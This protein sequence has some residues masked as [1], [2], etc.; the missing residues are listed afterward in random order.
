MVCEMGVYLN[1]VN[2]QEFKRLIEP[3]SD[4]AIASMRHGRTNK[5]G[6][7]FYAFF[8]RV[9]AKKHDDILRLDFTVKYSFDEN[10]REAQE[11]LEEAKSK[12]KEELKD[13]SLIE[14]EYTFKHELRY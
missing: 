3:H 2:L 6:I 11:L 10:D 13:Y 8:V 7:T 12:I 9:T 1:V 4:V 14:G 5:Q